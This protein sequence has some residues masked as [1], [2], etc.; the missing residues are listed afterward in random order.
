[1]DLSILCRCRGASES[2][3]HGGIA[4]PY[5]RVEGTWGIPGSL[6]RS[7]GDLTQFSRASCPRGCTSASSETSCSSPDTPESCPDTSW[8][9]WLFESILLFG[10]LPGGVGKPLAA[11]VVDV[12]LSTS[13]SMMCTSLAREIFSERLRY[14]SRPPM[15]RRGRTQ[16]YPVVVGTNYLGVTRPTDCC[17]HGR[18]M[19]YRVRHPRLSWT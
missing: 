15:L 14:G 19:Q 12:L 18:R 7:R 9:G 10:A 2:R 4:P 17:A 6:A 3:A 8:N 13:D 1:M 16:S 5:H 11:D